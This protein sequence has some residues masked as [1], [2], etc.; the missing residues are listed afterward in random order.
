M[1]QNQ[2][3]FVQAMQVQP[4]HQ[5]QP[6]AKP[7]SKKQEKNAAALAEL[8]KILDWII[9]T[10]VTRNNETIM[11]KVYSKDRALKELLEI[12]EEDGAPSYMQR[13]TLDTKII[14]QNVIT[15]HFDNKNLLSKLRTNPSS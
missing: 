13:L 3:Q 4:I 2:P 12:D 9:N 10:T 7:A 5:A 8:M 15:I 6:K 14:K 1:Q 11:R